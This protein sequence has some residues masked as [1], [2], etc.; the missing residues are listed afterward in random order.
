[1][2]TNK[3]KLFQSQWK[4]YNNCAIKKSLDIVIKHGYFC[5]T[6]SKKNILQRLDF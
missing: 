3:H 5:G 1:M 2:L 6:R 4:F